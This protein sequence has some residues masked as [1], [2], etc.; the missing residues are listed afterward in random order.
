MTQP[1]GPRLTARGA[2]AALAGLLILIALTLLA[3]RYGWLDLGASPRPVAAL[4][5]VSIATN[6]AY[7]GTC[8]VAAARENG[9]FADQGL[10]VT[11]QARSS[12]KAAME[13]V[14]Q[15]QANLGTVADIPV[16]FAGINNDPVT[17]IATIF[18]TERD[19]GL[20]ARRDRGIATPADLKGKRIGVT[21]DTSAH[22]ALDAMLN[23]H[24]LAPSD[25]TMINYRP[26]DLYDAMARG[27]ID[28]A[29]TWEPFLD[30]LLTQLGEN[31]R[32]F[33]GKDI[34]ESL[35]NIAGLRDYVRQ[36][37]RTMEK[38]LRALDRGARYCS[39]HPEAARA[40]MSSSSQSDDRQ[41]RASWPAYRFGVVLDQG[42]ILALED[43]ARWAMKNKLTAR[44]D[45]PNY[46]S[47][48]YLD[49]LEA[50]SP[51]AVTIIH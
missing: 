11:L 49:G 45:L 27:E 22:F 35:Y 47:F 46:L 25:V 10:L 5:Q 12:G 44:T 50:V 14:M 3:G 51:S 17:V 28:A 38:V 43:E 34:Y 15:G 37:P 40:L 19:H 1:S 7:A 42:L 6:S 8:P 24:G 30:A 39:S 26:E 2:I 13:A 21:L 48:I 29:A 32:A 41:L 31:G 16:M 18:R 36:Q 20:V 4:E 9:Y 23:R 33:Y